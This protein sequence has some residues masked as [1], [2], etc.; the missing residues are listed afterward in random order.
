MGG[1]EF[2]SGRVDSFVQM[3]SRTV[4]CRVSGAVCSGQVQSNIRPQLLHMAHFGLG[5]TQPAGG[6]G[7]PRSRPG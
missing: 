7:P 2:V 3:A 6:R 5:L 4:S 1:V